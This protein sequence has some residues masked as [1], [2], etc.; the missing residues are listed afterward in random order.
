MQPLASI[1]NVSANDLSRDRNDFP[2]TIDAYGLHRAT[3]VTSQVSS[4]SFAVGFTAED[5]IDLASNDMAKQ[6]RHELAMR[7]VVCI[8]VR[9]DARFA[10]IPRG[11]PFVSDFEPHGLRIHLC[12]PALAQRRWMARD[13]RI[14]VSQ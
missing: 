12:Q 7:L 14:A 11:Q 5:R 8:V 1:V 13:F 2:R 10:R 6:V 4:E 3:E 9:H